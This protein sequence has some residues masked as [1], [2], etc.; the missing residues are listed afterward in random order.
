[1]GTAISVK[2][3]DLIIEKLYSESIP[4]IAYY[5]RE[6][7]KVMRHGLLVGV[8]DHGVTIAD[9]QTDGKPLMDYLAVYMASGTTFWYGDQRDMP[10]ETRMEMTE[11]VADSVLAFCCPDGG[12]LNLYFSL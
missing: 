1:M 4:V 8:G 5:R 2:E 6:G 12:Q 11:I 9:A 3:A 7:V 10:T